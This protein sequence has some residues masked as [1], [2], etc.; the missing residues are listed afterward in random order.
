MVSA[1]PLVFA[2][3]TIKSGS[4][5][6]GP[7]NGKLTINTYVG[8]MGSKMGH[9]L[10]LEA[11]RWSG[12]LELNPDDP[13]SCSVEVTVD[14]RSLEVIQATGGLKPLSDKDK[15]DIAQNQEKTLQPGKFPEISFKS[16]S[17][18]GNVPKL[19][20][21]GD[22]TIMGNTK[23]VTLE[24]MVEEN[25][26]ETRV[27][28]KTTVVQTEFGVKPYSK[29]GALKVKDPVDIQVELTLPS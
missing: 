14:P 1:R 27:S 24:V 17:V 6:I 4:H 9:D 18:K 20:L 15:G 16:T 29:M 25:G 19:S 28:G 7:E 2:A 8:G 12:T 26:S 11:T 22:L 3:M 13:G 10:V 5:S 21:Q 23:P